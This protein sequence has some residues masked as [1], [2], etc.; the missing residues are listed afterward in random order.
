MYGETL[1]ERPEIQ[2]L[3]D[4][5]SLTLC[6]YVHLRIYT[7]SY[8]VSDSLVYEYAQVSSVELWIMELGD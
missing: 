3:S 5:T 2:H 8:R 1:L 7:H 6:M 4:T